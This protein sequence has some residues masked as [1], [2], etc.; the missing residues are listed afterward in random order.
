MITPEPS[1]RNFIHP[2]ECRGFGDAR[3]CMTT[4]T[5]LIITNTYEQWMCESCI[6]H[7]LDTS[8]P[9][10]VDG[11][12]DLIICSCGNTPHDDGFGIC[13]PNGVWCEDPSGNTPDLPWDGLHHRCAKC[14][15]VFIVPLEPVYE[16]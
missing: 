4:G 3:L 10:V 13:T 9:Y 14:N 7:C 5:H 11:H 2:C 1:G 16:G 6:N 8:E 12:T 15:H